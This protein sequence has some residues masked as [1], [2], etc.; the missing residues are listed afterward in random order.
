[1]HKFLVMRFFIVFL[2]F[3]SQIINAQ[4]LT[5]DLL[6]E[7][8]NH[9]SV[10]PNHTLLEKYNFIHIPEESDNKQNTY[11]NKSILKDWFITLTVFPVS[12]TCKNIISAVVGKNHDFALL[13]KH[14]LSKGYKFSGEKL[15]NAEITLL[16]YVKDNHAFSISKEITST[17]AYQIL[18]TCK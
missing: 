3:F 16:H 5:I 10:K 12:K 11:S 2:L 18:F 9:S 14:L 4:K 13:R 17:G 7:V 6:E 15:L 1:M 8:S